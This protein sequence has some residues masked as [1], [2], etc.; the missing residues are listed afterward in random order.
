MTDP[1]NDNPGSQQQVPTPGRIVEGFFR[2]LDEA[3]TRALDQLTPLVESQLQTLNELI[4][5]AQEDFTKGCGGLCESFEGEGPPPQEKLEDLEQVIEGQLAWL[6][7]RVRG[8]LDRELR[9]LSPG[10]TPLTQT[11]EKLQRDYAKQ[12]DQLPETLPLPCG[13]CPTNGEGEGRTVVSPIRMLAKTTLPRPTETRKH[14]LLT[15]HATAFAAVQAQLDDLWRSLRFHLEATMAELSAP[16]ETA[17]AAEQGKD[18]A[19]QLQAAHDQVAGILAASAEKLAAAGQP[20][21][22]FWSDL[23][24]RVQAEHQELCEALRRNIAESGLLR[25][26]L[27][28]AR[29]RFAERLVRLLPLRSIREQLEAADEGGPR[30]LKH[31]LLGLLGGLRQLTGEKDAEDSTLLTLTDL[32]SLEELARRTETLPRLYRRMFEQG[33]LLNREFMVG[34]ESPM[35][36]LEQIFTRW[37]QGKACSVAVIGPEG[38][39]KSSLLNCFESEYG[40]Q[41]PVLRRE[42]GQR[43]RSEAQVLELLKQWFEADAEVVSLNDLIAHIRSR[44]RCIVI[45]EE[46]HNLLLRVIGGRGAIQA[47]FRILVGTRGHCLWLV[48]FRRHP[49]QRM[50]DQFQIEQ[51]FTHQIPTLFHDQKQIEEALMLR[52]RTSGYPVLFLG[53]ADD[54]EGESAQEHLKET[55]FRELFEASGGNIKAALYFWLLCVD[56]NREENRLQLCS[57]G[58]LDH[59]FVRKLDRLYLFS[60]AEILCHGGLSV[61]EH[62]SIFRLDPVRSQLTLD[63]LQQLTL[64]ECKG[65]PAEGGTGRYVLS[66]VFYKAVTGSLES[67]HIVY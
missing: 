48:S 53:E 26:R 61:D 41:Q 3:L 24:D 2:G 19:N 10:R 8:G 32:P 34:R 17:E 14:P 43:L 31:R 50:N 9:K 46:G 18:Q 11:L 13:H 27:R 54:E 42:F 57:V 5:Q 1:M 39:G 7:K 12:G 49:W 51:Y 56:Y 30:G 37:Q 15:E 33:P 25:A 22:Q 21:Q 44:P 6:Y 4:A 29:K 45:A 62:A 59:S 28:R 55:F 66:P 64:L 20:L 38:S 67:M 36:Q 47:F 40:A 16:T 52:Q 58:K 65:A 60:L 35:L 23:P 63:Y